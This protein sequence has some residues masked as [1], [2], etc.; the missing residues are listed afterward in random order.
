MAFLD[1]YGGALRLP[2][3]AA[4]MFL[5]SGPD[6]VIAAC[7]NG[8]L[9]SFP[10]ANARTI[11]VLN[12]W[13]AQITQRLGDRPGVPW[14]ANLVVHPT[15]PRLSDELS[16]LE[17]ARVPVVIT[18]LGGPKPIV[19]RVHAWGGTVLADV[20][21]VAFAKKAV[22]AGV[23]GLI[24]VSA[25]AGGHTGR[26][27]GFS[28]LSAVREFFDGPIALGGGLSNGAEIRAVET[29]GAN[30]AVMGTAFIATEESLAVPEYKSM[31]IDSTIDDLVLT[32]TVTNVLA[33]WLRPTLVQAGIDPTDF[34]VNPK[35]DFSDSSL[36]E[37]QRVR[38][39]KVWSAGHGVGSVRRVDT[40]AE[41]VAR[42][43]REYLQA[44]DLPRNYC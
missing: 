12:E 29:A 5:V 1:E 9:G 41:L 37:K 4:P 3:I 28:L 8:V 27:N 15:N 10:C 6:L 7:A 25:G 43:R 30:L 14:A 38:W 44:C 42:L 18:A 40:V 33:N 21:S 19:D 13:I 36:I 34:L 39:T 2:L 32:N 16:V 17:N 26:M 20:N 11:E 31:L 24:L 35:V 23:D 22:D